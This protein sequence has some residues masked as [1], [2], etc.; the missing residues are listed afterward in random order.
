MADQTTTTKTLDVQC[1]DV[2][3]ALVTYKIDNY[4]DSVTKIAVI[5]AFENAI[6]NQLL[7]SSKSGALLQRVAKVTKSESIKTVLDNQTIYI[8]PSNIDITTGKGDTT[9]TVT[10]GICQ[11]TNIENFVVSNDTGTGDMTE[12]FVLYADVS[13]NG[14]TITV[15]LARKDSNVLPYSGA[16][17]TAEIKIIIGGLEYNVPYKNTFT[18][19]N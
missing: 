16:V 19:I 14:A 3:G 18:Q 12:H 9:I 10:D 1:M 5:N 6:G 7:I 4:K 17:A 2:N 15:T 11:G 13:S 8:T